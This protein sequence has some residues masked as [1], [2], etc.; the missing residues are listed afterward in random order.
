[1]PGALGI[2]QIARNHLRTKFF[3]AL[4]DDSVPDEVLIGVN[5]RKSLFKRDLQTQRK[6]GKLDVI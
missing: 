3:K 1:M 4:R 6:M 2:D 5:V